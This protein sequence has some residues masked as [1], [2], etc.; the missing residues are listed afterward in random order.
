MVK[1]LDSTTF[2]DCLEHYERQHLAD[3]PSDSAA[4]TTPSNITGAN[5]STTHNMPV[6]VFGASP[7][8]AGPSHLDAKT[9]IT[10]SGN[11]SNSSCQRCEQYQDVISNLLWKV[12]VNC[13][14]EPV[15]AWNVLGIHVQP[16]PQGCTPQRNRC[17]SHY[18][19]ST[20]HWITPSMH[21]YF[22]IYCHCS[23][24][25]PHLTSAASPLGIQMGLGYAADSS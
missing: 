13:I 7:H 19:N 11:L 23:C 24:C 18:S 21:L 14:G 17:L 16:A 4:T 12:N 3:G 10:W 22:S 2:G 8:E 6:N 5:T 25:Q 9:G 15:A 20:T 1:V